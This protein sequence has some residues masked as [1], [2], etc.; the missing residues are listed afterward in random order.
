MSTPKL[1]DGKFK[2]GNKVAEKW[3]EDS[4]LCKLEEILSFVVENNVTYIVIALAHFDL[5]KDLW[6]YWIDKYKE[7]ESVFL[8]IKKI[9][10]KIESNLYQ[11]GLTSK[12][13]TM[14]IFTLKNHHSW[15]DK[16]EQEV[17]SE[18][19]ITWVEEKTY[20]NASDNQTNPG[21]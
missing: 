21:S 8:L 3:T 5:Y 12:N 14:A 15:V 2:V 13:P 18:T 6:T 17:K 7:N 9:Q 10:S 20:P 11:H 4:V 16:T 19:S 1:N